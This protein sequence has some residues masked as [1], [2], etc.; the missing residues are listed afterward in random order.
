[1]ADITQWPGL[2]T[3]SDPHDIPFGG[4]VV[5]DNFQ[6]VDGKLRVRPGLQSHTFPTDHPDITSTADV[7]CMYAWRQAATPYIAILCSNGVVYQADFASSNN[8][9]PVNVTRPS[10]WAHDRLGNLIRVNGKARGSLY[11]NTD[12]GGSNYYRNLGMT[13]PTGAPAATAAGSGGSLTA[14]TYWCAYRFVDDDGIASA[15][16]PVTQ[17]T[18]VDNDA[19]TWSTVDGGNSSR[20]QQNLE[21]YRTASQEASVFYK[22]KTYD[23]AQTTLNWSDTASDNTISGYSSLSVLNPDGTLCARRQVVPPTNMDLV[24]AFQDRVFYASSDT[25]VTARR[26]VIL[27]SEVDEPE[28]VPATQNILVVQDNAG[29]ADWITALGGFGSQLMIFQERHT[30]LL[31]YSYSPV[32]DGAITLWLSRGCINQRCWQKHEDVL[33][34][35]DMFGC[36]KMS[37]G[38]YSRISDPIADY[39]S[40]ATICFTNKLWFFSSLD[41]VNNVIRW[42]VQFDGDEDSYTRPTRALCYDIETGAWWTESYPI[43]L[44]GSVVVEQS[45]QMRTLIGAEN[46]KIL[47][48]NEGTS[49]IISTAVSGT[50]TA[51]DATSITDSTAAF[52]AA[53]VDAPVVITGGTGQGQVRTITSRT[54]T[55]LTVATWTTTPDTTSTYTVGGIKATYQSGLAPIPKKST[56]EDDGERSLLITYAPTSNAEKIHVGLMWDHDT[57][58]ASMA[59]PG[60][61]GGVSWK[62]GS[63]Y[64]TIDMEQDRSNLSNSPG[65]EAIRFRARNDD[66]VIGHRFLSF[67]FE[68]Y[69]GSEAITIYDTEVEGV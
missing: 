12:A 46:D 27:Y 34:S 53:M 13:A 68:A 63:T 15:L 40:D 29:A 3:R 2:F 62:S 64:I 55:K 28:S 41:P 16:S 56:K 33:Y 65:Y 59:Q 26:N 57:S 49:D 4:A 30:Y 43:E 60:D 61:D 32:V 25:T 69:A 5:Q 66:R 38:Q 36:W 1:M 14:G 48:L 10:N 50:V 35:M 39:W 42:H 9:S 24:C 18:A 21:L 8:E 54:A 6:P 45:G 19:I 52:T 58:A 7:Y 17:I 23:P 37:G 51:S 67:T 22:V 47:A 11:N 44:S 31:R 20:E